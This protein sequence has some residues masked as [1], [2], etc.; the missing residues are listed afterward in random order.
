MEVGERASG[1]RRERP[2]AIFERR[3]HAKNASEIGHPRPPMRNPQAPIVRTGIALGSNI[4]D[5]LERLREARTAILNLAGVGAPMK[6]SR[7][8]ETRPVNL[9][10]GAGAFLNAVI[11]VE[12]DGQPIVLLDGLQTIEAGMGRPSK[13][14]RN[15]SRTIDVDILYVGNL[16]LHND[17]VVI[18]HPRLH[19]RR[20]VL[21][22]LGDIRPELVLP[23]QQ[24][25]ISELLANLPH[26]GGVE[27]FRGEWEA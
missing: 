11:E 10:P 25:T 6:A 8:Y 15:A 19:Q 26:P 9:E 13:R 16:V 5:R 14:P 27:V 23:G 3:A 21:A 4:G 20:F 2:T 7:I 24:R 12:Y 17:E 18:P 1:S 22:P